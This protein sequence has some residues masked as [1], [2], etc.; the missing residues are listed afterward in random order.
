[1]R[2]YDTD[3]DNPIDGTNFTSELLAMLRDLTQRDPSDEPIDLSPEGLAGLNGLLN[4]AFR[5]KTRN[6]W[7]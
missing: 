4:M 6:F 3:R 7:R 5:E 2:Y 1:M